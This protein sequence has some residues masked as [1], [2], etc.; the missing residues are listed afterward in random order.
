MNIRLKLSAVCLGGLGPAA[1]TGLGV[2]AAVSS[3]VRLELGVSADCVAAQH[4][5]SASKPLGITF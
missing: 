3:A 2:N 1:A 4:F 5:E